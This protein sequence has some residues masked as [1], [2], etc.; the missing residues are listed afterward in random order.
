MHGLI[1]RTFSAA[2]V[3]VTLSTGLYGYKNDYNLKYLDIRLET[4]NVG[5]AWTGSEFQRICYI[6]AS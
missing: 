4:I 1:V 3:Q 6:L 5:A 2:L